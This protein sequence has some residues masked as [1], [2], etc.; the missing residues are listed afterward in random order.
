MILI[1]FNFDFPSEMMGEALTE[2]LKELAESIN[3]EPGFISKIWIENP[4]T[5]KSGGIYLFEDQKS[6]ENYVQMHTSRVEAIGAKNIECR[7]FSV[8]ETL[9]K[10]NQGI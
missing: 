7:F 4:Q 5:G 8:N 10:I 1:Q 9:S 6:A 2:N 3:Q